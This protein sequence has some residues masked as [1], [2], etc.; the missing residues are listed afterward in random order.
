MSKVFASTFIWC[1]TFYVFT[2]TEQRGRAAE[3]AIITVLHP[4]S[5]C[6]AERRAE[7][8]LLHSGGVPGGLLTSN[9]LYVIIHVISFFFELASTNF[10]ITQWES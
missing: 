6:H 4:D 9:N 3:S 7:S 8:F 10:F 1:S 5:G 2:V